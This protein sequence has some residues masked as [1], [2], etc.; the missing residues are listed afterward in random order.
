MQKFSWHLLSA[1]TS[2]TVSAKEKEGSGWVTAA[3]WGVVRGWLFSVGSN[4]VLAG[5]GTTCKLKHII[6]CQIR[7]QQCEYSVTKSVKPGYFLP[8]E[9]K[10]LLDCSIVDIHHVTCK[11]LSV[12]LMWSISRA[13][14]S[15]FTCEPTAWCWV[16]GVFIT[17]V[18]ALQ[19]HGWLWPLKSLVV[20][21]SW[22]SSTH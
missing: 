14:K 12:W 2:N 17:S 5:L 3:K 9:M 8:S 1:P 4:P 20:N 13:Y 6:P 21:I 16:H 22:P 15:A 10:L 7:C 11:L 19:S 18:V